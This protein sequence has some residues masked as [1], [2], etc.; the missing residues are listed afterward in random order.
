MLQLIMTIISDGIIGVLS[1]A[2]NRSPLYV[3]YYVTARCNLRCEQ[4]NVIY[5]NSDLSES[6]TLKTVEAIHNLGQIGTKVLLLTGGEPFVRSDIPILVKEAIKNKIHPR[7]QTNGAASKQKLIDCAENGANDI[8]ISLDSLN[9]HN[10]DF[11][12]GQFINSWESAISSIANINETFPSNSF[13]ALGCVF[14]PY[15]FMEVH[16]VIKFATEIGWYVS[17]VPAHTTDSI[18]PRSFSTFDSRLRFK[19]DE[20][21]LALDEIDK[22]IEMKKM[23]YKVYDSIT[24]LE[25]MKKFIAGEKLDWRD[26]NGGKCDATK[27]YFAVLPDTQFSICC[28]YRLENKTVYV[29]DQDFPKIYKSGVLTEMAIDK[30]SSCSGC[31]YGSYPE[32][33]ISA[34]YI[35]SI[36]ERIPEFLVPRQNNIKKLNFSDLIEL[37]RKINNG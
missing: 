5:A 35:E 28:D 26:R 22:I 16:K 21:P 31:L 4:C 25:N 30:L 6:S 24:F 3:Q 33:T 12:N 29:S 10:Q 11:I 18:S 17:L 27:Y 37:S 8:S 34:R 23:G 2:L 9:P 32:I 1:T 7:L 36:I 19:P 13:C 15:N 20:I 14:S